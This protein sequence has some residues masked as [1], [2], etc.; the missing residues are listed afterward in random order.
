[1]GTL[2][3]YESTLARSEASYR[4]LIESMP[5]GVIVGRKGAVVYLSPSMRRMLGYSREDPVVGMKVLDLVHPDDRQQASER[6][7]ALVSSGGAVPPIE[8]R[9]LRHDG[10]HVIT[11]LQAMETVF[12]GEPAILAIARD[13]TARKEVEAKLMLNDRLASL[14]R[15]AASVGHELNNPL[16]YVLGNIA[17]L[18]RKLVD[19]DVPAA[20][21]ERLSSY[22]K[23]IGDG[24]RRMRDIVRDLKTLARSDA[25]ESRR[26]DLRFLL[27]VAANMAEHEL[28]AGTKLVREYRDELVVVGNE[29]RLG[30]VFLNL[31]V[32]AAQ[33]IPEG[34]G[35]GEVR[36]VTR[37]VGTSA[38]VEISD[39]GSGVPRALV[40]RIFEPFFTTKAGVGTGLGLSISHRI[41]VSAGGTIVCDARP[42]GGTTFRVTLPCA[43]APPA[44]PES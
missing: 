6:I 12:D 8:E 24:A 27:D 11:E 44:P 32:N 15:L 23:V 25:P 2:E 22:V 26:V 9:L 1:L 10:T 3:A 34:Q 31:L 16:T 36:I 5:D 14:G 37:A 33:S 17:L 40:D 42:G 21:A 13:V 7:Y 38:V 18:E 28:R 20:A 35:E 43:E 4:A 39:T 19:S 29:T 41:V 30:Q